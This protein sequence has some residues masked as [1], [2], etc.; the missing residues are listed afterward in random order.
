MTTTESKFDEYFVRAA[1]A[2]YIWVACSDGPIKDIEISHFLNYL[3]ESPFVD[4]ITDDQFSEIF[5]NLLELFDRDF[6]AGKARA[7]LRLSVF[8]EDKERAHSL[9]RIARKALVSDSELGEREEIVLAEIATLL[10][11]S[12]ADVDS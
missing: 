1:A 12:E 9:F 4:Q 11:I 10:N 6:E 7:I 5:L 2:S 8:K 3:N